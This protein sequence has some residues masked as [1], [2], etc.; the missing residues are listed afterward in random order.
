MEHVE[1]AR[2]ATIK[3]YQLDQVTAEPQFDT[4]S[5]MAAD[6]FKVP[7]SAVTVLTL[8]RQL[9]PSSCGIDA[10]ETDR[11][12]AFCNFTVQGTEVFVVED[13]LLDPRFCDHAMVVGEPNIRFYAGAPIRIGDDIPIGALCVVDRQP[14][15]FFARDRVQL[16]QMAEIIAG[17]MELRLGSRLSEQR[18]REVYAQA[19]LSRAMID[20]V[21]QGIAL[22]DPEG[23]LILTN[24]QLFSLLHLS[25]IAANKPNSTVNELLF[26]AVSTGSFGQLDPAEFSQGLTDRSADRGFKM[27]ELRDVDGRVLEI[28]YTGI[29]RG[30]SILTVDDI[31][32]RHKLIRLKDEF[33]STASHELRTPLTSIRGALAILGKRAEDT[34]DP[35]GRQML[36]M[37][38]R[39][40]ERLTELVNDILD[41]GKLGSPEMSMRYEHIDV[42]HVLRDSC[43]QIR[44]Y[45]LSHNVTINLISNAT[46]PMLGDAGRLQQAVTNLLSN[47]CK[48]SSADSEVNVIGLVQDEKIIVTVEDFGRGIPIEFREQM[49]RRFAQADAQHRSGVTGTGLGLAITKAIVE[50]H[51]GEIGYES[52]IGVGT[53]FQIS[54]PKLLP[55]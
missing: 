26:S 36:N 13:T 35:Q 8:D 51:Q 31:S 28:R 11:A 44:P 54:L 34:L 49:F 7:M 20:N 52:E 38:S 2:Q 9:L 50:Q 17:I 24:K 37:A 43:E 45:A 33:I 39:N 32:E 1:I 14:R 21:L 25:P 55:N 10:T 12:D 29:E 5:R 19:E 27:V 46:L 30:R 53:R 41:I 23:L 6:L 47:A 15:Q 3:Q 42:R 16:A 40:A 18:Q 4:V 22:V 48:F